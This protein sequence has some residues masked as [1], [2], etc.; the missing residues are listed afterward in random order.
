M[1]EFM[2]ALCFIGLL[3]AFGAAV[4]NWAEGPM[5][6]LV[7]IWDKRSLSVPTKLDLKQFLGI[8]GK[9]LPMRR[10]AI[11]L[12]ANDRLHVLAK[13]EVGTL[14]T[15]DEVALI[16]HHIGA[17]AQQSRTLR[18]LVVRG[19]HPLAVA[20]R[21]LSLQQSSGSDMIRPCSECSS[22]R[23]DGPIILVP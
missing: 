8:Y 2:A 4:I 6:S 3:G 9:A 12:A 11:A 7:V 21:K 1:K 19:S 16:H 15:V 10:G 18:C 14:L 17:Q 23:D 22:R 13:G 20:A 5:I